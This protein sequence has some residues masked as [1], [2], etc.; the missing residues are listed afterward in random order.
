MPKPDPESTESRAFC[1]SDE[2]E[3]RYLEMDA[4]DAAEHKR[5]MLH[6][7]CS[8]HPARDGRTTHC[9][10]HCCSIWHEH[11]HSP[12]KI[13]SYEEIKANWL[14]VQSKTDEQSKKQEHAILIRKVKSRTEAEAKRRE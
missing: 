1:K 6:D 4:T 9:G 3:K 12:H 5:H 7:E 13:I 10:A 11:R 2:G 14:S 8:E